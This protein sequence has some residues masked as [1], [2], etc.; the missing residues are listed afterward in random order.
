MSFDMVESSSI[1]LTALH[2]LIHLRQRLLVVIEQNDKVEFYFLA[3]VLE[4]LERSTYD[5][6][7][8]LG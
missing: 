6:A 4:N 1:R 5:Y 3:R 8:G 7:S 2:L